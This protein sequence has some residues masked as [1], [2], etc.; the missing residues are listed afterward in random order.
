MFLVSRDTVMNPTALKVRQLPRKF[1]GRVILW[2]V[3]GGPGLWARVIFEVE[4]LRYLTALLP[5]GLAALIWRDSALA[6]AQAPLPMLFVIYVFESRFLRLPKAR[7]AALV[8]AAEA[9]RGLDLLRSRAI[10]ILTRI[11]AGR[12]LGAVRLHLVIEQSDLWRVPPLTYVS[13]QSE[14]G[15]AVLRL[16]AEEKALIR[17]TLFAAP[18]TEAELHRINIAQATPLRDIVLE[19]GRVSAHARMAALMAQR[20]DKAKAGVGGA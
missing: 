4:L 15:P 16:S 20:Q 14:D 7:R 3:R 2:P 9:D 19:P 6:I 5:F 11:A 13:V 8:E 12:G 10:A 18:L 1:F 17:E